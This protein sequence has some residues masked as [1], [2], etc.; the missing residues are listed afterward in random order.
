MVQKSSKILEHVHKNNQ[1]C[2]KNWSK[3]LQNPSQE[4]S[5]RLLGGLWRGLGGI[6]APRRLQEPKS[7]QKSNSFL[8]FWLPKSYQNPSKI[9][10]EAIQKVL[11]FL[12]SFLI[13]FWRILDRFLEL[14]SIK[15]LSKINLKSNSK[16]YYV[17]DWF[18][19][20]I[21]RVARSAERPKS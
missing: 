14:K 5:W 17:F 3:M 6:L 15:S 21:L 19:L 20:G 11:I 2:I 9:D 8:P 4:A 18:L 16:N 10:L 12:I 7:V 1:K 13:D